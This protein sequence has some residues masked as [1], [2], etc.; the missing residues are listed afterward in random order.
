MNDM[1]TGLSIGAA[2]KGW[3]RTLQ[4]VALLALVFVLLM[5]SLRA[6][7]IWDDF[8]QI[9]DSPTVGDPENIPTYF[10]HNVIQSAG[11][12]GRGAPG[13]DLYRPLFMTSLTAVYAIDGADPF[14]FHLAVLV[15]HLLVCALLWALAVRWLGSPLAAALGVLFFACH[16]VTAEAYLWAS[17]ISEPMAAAGLL[18]AVLLLDHGCRE[19]D[20]GWAAAVLAGFV[21]FAGLLSKEAVLMALPAASLYLWR[22]RGVR[23]RHLAPLWIAAAC[24]LVLR[25]WALGGL[26]AGGAGGGQRL[27]ALRNYPVLLIDGLRAMLGMLPVGIRHLSWEYDHVTWGLSLAAA[28]VCLVILGVALALRTKTPLLLLAALVTGL[29]LAPIAL[30]STIPGWGGFGR[31]L[32]VPLAFLTLA[33]GEMGLTAQRWLRAHRPRLRLAVPLLV[34]AVLLVEQVGLRRALWTY[35]NQENLARSAIEIYPDGPDGYEWLGNVYVERGDLAAAL[36]CFRAA[37]ERGPELYR[38]RHNLA[39]ALLYTGHPEEALQQLAIAESLHGTT[40]DGSVIAVTAMMELG[41]WDEAATR[42][43]HALEKAPDDPALRALARRFATEHPRPDELPP[44][45]TGRPPS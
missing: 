8:H 42:L 28:A 41:R 6:G 19:K 23:L 15:A 4:L 27:D 37:T 18:G 44:G 35:A 16:P 7:F 38:P 5:P 29:M 25:A 17:A 20:G 11:G 26:Q 22:P 3:G 9:V 2:T 10:T 43:L 45:L 1:G 32:Y 36:R 30:V 24:F 40:S 14:W 31:Y 12:E 39:A 33:L 13:V 21:L 34:A